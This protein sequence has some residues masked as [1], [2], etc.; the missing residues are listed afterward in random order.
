LEE[1]DFL[2]GDEEE[3]VEES[4]SGANEDPEGS[5][6]TVGAEEEEVVVVVVGLDWG[7]VRDGDAVDERGAGLGRGA[8]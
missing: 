8:E 1:R 6:A 4:S 7:E 5:G 2:F 3:P